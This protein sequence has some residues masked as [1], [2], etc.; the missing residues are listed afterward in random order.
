MPF[1]AAA[2]KKKLAEKKAVADSVPASVIRPT[3]AAPITT[4]DTP[5]SGGFSYSVFK[6]KLAEKK[7]GRSASKTPEIFTPEY[8]RSIYNQ[9]APATRA[10]PP[11][12]PLDLG[13]QINTNTGG[14]TTQA[15]TLDRRAIAEQAARGETISTL[16]A[17]TKLPELSVTD[18]IKLTGDAATAEMDKKRKENMK[19]FFTKVQEIKDKPSQLVPFLAGA[20][21]AKEIY[22]LSQVLG[23][24]E[25]GTATKEDIEKAY[26][27]IE[28][29]EKES[30]FGYNVLNI[31]SMLP[32]FAGEIFTTKGLYTA[33]RKVATEAAEKVVK[34]YLVKGGKEMLEKKLA[35]NLMMKITTGL[36]GTAAITPLAGSTRITASTMEKMLPD[37]TVYK[38][39][40]GEL[41]AVILGEGDSLPT[42]FTKAFGEQ[43]VELASERAGSVLP[44]LKFYNKLDTATK[45]YLMRIAFIKSFQKLNPT[46][47]LADFRKV[48]K[49]AGW[50][51]VVGEMFEERV[52]DVGHGMLAEAGFGDQPLKLP[53][54]QQLAEELV[55]FS[56]IGGG[57]NLGERAIER[58]AQRG[59]AAGVERGVVPPAGPSG[60]S[61]PAGPAGPTGLTPAAADALAGLP[62]AAQVAQPNIPP[63]GRKTGIIT[64]EN[65]ETA[66]DYTTLISDTAK[67]SESMEEFKS[68]V[69]G[70]AYNKV[71]DDSYVEPINFDSE[72]AGMAL[73]H[74]LG[75]DFENKMVVPGGQQLLPEFADS[76]SGAIVIDE[77]GKV[78]QGFEDLL[79]TYY[80]N[81][82]QNKTSLPGIKVTPAG[83][84]GRPTNKQ[85]KL[86]EIYT[87]AQRQTRMFPGRTPEGQPIVFRGQPVATAAP[88]IA[89][90]VGKP[91]P[92]KPAAPQGTAIG[93]IAAEREREKTNADF[94]EGDTVAFRKIKNGKLTT[95][96]DSKPYRIKQLFA[97]GEIDN[98]EHILLEDDK[99]KELYTTPAGIEKVKPQYAMAPAPVKPVKKE[100]PKEV[101]EAPVKKAAPKKEKPSI[102]DAQRAKLMG[103]AVNPGVVERIGAALGEAIAEAEGEAPA[104]QKEKVKQAVAEQPKTIKQVAE[105]TGILA[106]NVRRILGMGAKDGT[107]TR[108]EKG[109]YVMTMKNGQDVAFIYPSD[110]IETL[111]KLAEE[112]FKADM[113]FLDIP[114]IT[115]GI[116]SAN[117]QLA[118]KGI[119]PDQFRTVVKAVK[120]IAKTDDTP[121]FHMFSQSKTGEKDMAVYNKVLLDEGLKPIAKGNY[122]KVSKEGKPLTQP[123]RTAPLP[124]EGILLLS[125]S[126]KINTDKAITLDFT[127]TRPRGYTTEKPEELL[128][129]LI[130]LGTREGDMVLDPFAGSGVTGAAAIKSGRRATLIE[131]GVWFDTK[132]EAKLDE[133][134]NPIKIVEEFTV[135][136]VQA[137]VEEAR[138]RE[139]RPAE[140]TDLQAAIESG[141]KVAYTVEG[142][143]KTYT[144]TAYKNGFRRFV[145]GEYDQ[146]YSEH[147]L[148]E[149]KESLAKYIK[150][151]APKREVPQRAV[152]TRVGVSLV[153]PGEAYAKEERGRPIEPT[154]AK[155]LRITID[156]DAIASYVDSKKTTK[157]RTANINDLIIRQKRGVTTKFLELP[158][159]KNRET[160]SYGFLYNLSKSDSFGI[161][162]NE[163]EII[164][165]VLNTKFK[166]QKSINMADFRREVLDN[167]LPLEMRRTSSHATAGMS[168]IGLD[169]LE[170]TTYIFN[171][172]FAHGETGHF[173][174]DYD[175]FI[176][177]KEEDLEIKKVPAQRGNPT[178]QYAV[179]RKGITLT[180]DNI[181][182]YVYT[183]ADTED[184][185]KQWISQRLETGKNILPRRGELA[186]FGTKGLFAHFRAADD[187]EKKKTYIPEWQGDPFQR[188]RVE[189]F[190]Q[191]GRISAIEERLS[192]YDDQ[193]ARA[194][195]FRIDYERE[196]FN[197]QNAIKFID[198]KEFKK[199]NPKQGEFKYVVLPAD[200]QIPGVVDSDVN[201]HFVDRI[202]A[203]VEDGKFNA[204]A[205]V[206]HMKSKME[207]AEGSI[208]NYKEDLEQYNKEKQELTDELKK[209][210]E[211]PMSKEEKLFRDYTDT[212]Y[213]RLVREAISTK[214]NEGFKELYFPTPRTVAMV[215]GYSGAPGIPDE[216]GDY[217]PYELINTN[218]NEDLSV[219]DEIEYLGDRHTVLEADNYNITVSKSSDV[220]HFSADDYMRDDIQGRWEET[221]SELKSVEKD[222]NIK[223]TTP[224]A[225]QE[226]L[227]MIPIVNQHAAYNSKAEDTERVKKELDDKMKEEN[228][229]LASRV[230]TLEKYTK[231]HKL[232]VKKV[233]VKEGITKERIHDLRFKDRLEEKY[234]IPHSFWNYIIDPYRDDEPTLNQ[235]NE[236]TRA[237]IYP[238]V[239]EAKTRLKEQ[240]D[241]ISDLQDEYID[242]LKKIADRE[243]PSEGASKGIPKELIK[244]RTNNYWL[245]SGTDRVLEWMADELEETKFKD[246]DAIAEAYEQ[247]YS[248]DMAENYDPDFE[249]MYG[250]DNVFFVE[251]GYD[252]EVWVTEGET[253]TLSQPDQYEEVVDKDPEEFDIEKFSDSNYTVL[254]FYEQQLL[255]YVNKLRRGN[256]ELVTDEN[257]VQWLKTK[258]TKEDKQPPTAY[259][260]K[261]NLAKI[262]LPITD[263]Q[264]VEILKLNKEIF[265]DT[266]IRI[267]GQILANDEALGSYRDRIIKILDR[268]GDPKSTFY[269]EAVHKYLDVFTTRQEYIDLLKEA[270]A[271]YQLK[272]L[273]AV[274]EKLA[275]DFIQYAK[276]REGVYGKLRLLFDKIL[277]RIGQYIGNEKKIAKLYNDIASGKAARQATVNVPVTIAKPGEFP[278]DEGPTGR[279]VMAKVMSQG[280]QIYTDLQKR[281]K[282]AKNFNEFLSSLT[283]PERQIISRKMNDTDVDRSIARFYT[284]I[285]KGETA[286]LR[287]LT[288]DALTKATMRMLQVRAKLQ[289]SR[290][291]T[292]QDRNGGGIAAAE[293]DRQWDMATDFQKIAPPEQW[294]IYKELTNY[295]KLVLESSAK[296][297]GYF[298]HPKEGLPGY[299]GLE[300][301]LFKSADGYKHLASV[302]AHEL[303]HMFDYHPE[304]TMAKG[305][306]LGRLYN[307]VYSF[308]N[309]FLEDPQVA[310]RINKIRNELMPAIMRDINQ[311]KDLVKNREKMQRLEH[312]LDGLERGDIIK[313]SDV[314][315]E[316]VELSKIRRPAL[317]ESQAAKS[318]RYRNSAKELYADY[319]ST[320]FNNPNQAFEIAPI[321]TSRFF[322]KLQNKPD[323]YKQML[324]IQHILSNGSLATMENRVKNLMRMF[325]RSEDAYKGAL[326]ERMVNKTSLWDS[327]QD[328]FY[329]KYQAVIDK[330]MEK[331]EEM[332]KDPYLDPR[333]FM[334]RYDYVSDIMHEAIT[335]N[336]QQFY[337]EMLELGIEPAEM[338]ALLFAQRIA[339]DPKR[340]DVANPGAYTPAT[341]KEVEDYFKS[342]T[343]NKEKAKKMFEL[344][345]KF[346]QG[347]LNVIKTYPDL[348]PPEL[349]AEIKAMEM[350]GMENFYAPFN[351]AQGIRDYLPPGMYHQTGNLN[352]TNNILHNI[353]LKMIGVV[354]AGEKNVAHGKLIMTL[355]KYFPED[356]TKAKT[357]P[358][359]RVIG[360]DVNGNPVIIYVH[361]PLPPMDRSKGTISAR[362]G[363]Q[364][365]SFYIPIAI[366]QSL[367]NAPPHA[368]ALFANV[369]NNLQS[370]SKKSFTV[371]SPAFQMINFVIRDPGTT[372]DTFR[373]VERATWNPLRHLKAIGKMVQYYGKATGHATGFVRGNYSGVVRGMLKKGRLISD[374][375]TEEKLKTLLDS[376]DF[377][378]IDA[379]LRKK[380]IS[381]F[382]RDIEEGLMKRIAG[383]VAYPVIKLYHAM[384]G[385]GQALEAIPKI[386]AEMYLT[387]K[388]FFPTEEEQT[389]WITNRVGSPNFRKKGRATGEIS[390]IMMF[391]NATLRGLETMA[392]L[393]IDPR[394]RAAVAWGTFYFVFLPTLVT[395]MAELGLF[396]GDDEER[397]KLKSLADQVPEQRKVNNFVIPIGKYEGKAMAIKIPMSEKDRF[398]HAIIRYAL[399]SIMD[400]EERNLKDMAV[401]IGQSLNY[402]VEQ[403]P[404]VAPLWTVMFAAYNTLKGVNPVDP[405]T[406]QNVFRGMGDTSQMNLG[407]L[408]K[409]EIFAKWAGQKLGLSTYTA[410]IPGMG[411]ILYE[412]KA[413]SKM[414]WQR[415]IAENLIGRRFFEIT[416]AG[417]TE[418]TREVQRPAK[419]VIAEK[420]EFKDQ[421][422]KKAV[423]EFKTN[424]P[425]NTGAFVQDNII[426]K[427][428]TR[429]TDEERLN[430]IDAFTLGVVKQ[431][432]ITKLKQLTGTTN[433]KL[434]AVL[435]D[436]WERN[437]PADEYKPLF[438]MAVANGIITEATVNELI[439][440]KAERLNQ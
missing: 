182:N 205:F 174:G 260:L 177:V 229:V 198:S 296:Y 421:V 337:Q 286:N 275:E 159:V 196:L 316:L 209:V 9:P 149:A 265:G 349:M 323:V 353:L 384:T 334:G 62:A 428:D 368:L 249:G 150:N 309:S 75:E 147:T 388:A 429:F 382:E 15:D 172:P 331:K 43:F 6:Q 322:D 336:F 55:A 324:E 166:D 226:V 99:G 418:H 101:P 282:N 241:K 84:V 299:I 430:A 243:K 400:E 318:V 239:M 47:K 143:G 225:A 148:E 76:G 311:G 66:P 236:K 118:Y 190:G 395:T 140:K 104:T 54:A 202:N 425:K 224:A 126:G 433:P 221:L 93:E 120:D 319:M 293:F 406:K 116:R 371:L 102:T 245:D 7:A 22:D 258:L 41:K 111:P 175:D 424:P 49:A 30:T 20:T 348:F 408:R 74:T 103:N 279:Q 8:A 381:V 327:I 130:K 412:N 138:K 212:W 105:E 68:R 179:V 291:D 57:V 342:Q 121:I 173:S 255:K 163:K 218:E 11:A 135:P 27:V 404:S 98:K 252:T 208:K 289:A 417:E 301:D 340:Q 115:A 254:K 278:I 356:I 117:R 142:N 256:L 238:K 21:E 347:L 127:L 277:L 107:F 375:H 403:L 345:K 284:N 158:D 165:N 45:E 264:E 65:L 195:S 137:A 346:R 380:G 95:E 386:A 372:L 71:S 25:D 145:D 257:K 108:V 59:Q 38:D 422:I 82:G 178:D 183:V 201:R 367:E 96:L 392:K 435:L 18:Q 216:E 321:F 413:S 343:D 303:G 39:E 360:R 176:G 228:Q 378:A 40:Q 110:A 72:T 151:T 189:R 231:L 297:Y 192:A 396:G 390:A 60:P 78:L 357:S 152:P 266:D 426:S 4:A 56:L 28:D 420:D 434:K 36:V 325:K 42:A 268:Q 220:H 439:N 397:K 170:A 270:Q 391:Y 106:P 141:E 162:Q 402:A 53:S 411:D 132:G 370:F 335:T 419:Q 88:V 302:F 37:F 211:A 199:M 131:N 251:N 365:K 405:Y 415:A 232:L 246:I 32:S 26:K 155:T 12:E 398:A 133:A 35:E 272:D 2:F 70:S 326:K 369:I 122:T 308:R 77:N 79:D 354:Y 46:A 169:N 197:M 33:S 376:E 358:E 13:L 364:L 329:Y 19:T 235:V 124:P 298:A 5:V 280:E 125:K 253:E 180:P 14:T 213:Q 48:L 230:D 100:E 410:I 267:T 144:L 153:R 359:G 259:R 287:G 167:V 248:E 119:T 85:L 168:R 295:A 393:W 61:G 171:S 23:R 44:E 185:A 383:K 261:D 262:G 191:Q 300:R 263:K 269:H 407:K 1:D 69:L 338:S 67:E 134:G 29:S 207:S 86:N 350:L 80:E 164:Q 362:I 94:K 366:A 274:E 290:Y 373:M 306:V 341:A 437:L 285:T 203:Y 333:N 244:D 250:R 242:R 339:H 438:D 17:G 399:L 317:W 184:Q 109:V 161:K 436:D 194:I 114:Y 3:T 307:L 292:A 89:K 81:L 16:P 355:Q 128:T 379:T 401:N 363:G 352:D 351:I 427:L 283:E 294:I 320:L 332:N 92:V 223:L 52:A 304:F 423:E 247:K 387:D 414:T 123:M 344:A 90:P 227:N 64:T 312:E 187:M 83:K 146:T 58:A 97:V 219:G 276:S 215:E 330:A 217:M 361:K 113:V 377:S 271:Q 440:I 50:N 394:S 210:K 181:E 24:V 328:A 154:K 157:F 34:K 281:A 214:A 222:F 91:K 305:D 237:I 310:D 63:T 409:A 389:F 160:G 273:A 385:V 186:T 10:T 374:Y 431:S 233:V 136:R 188:S 204:D 129:A 73:S 193:I 240:Q 313:N 416:S 432:N 234:G 112:G 139:R 87:G 315:A 156:D 51:G 288:G 206:V 314:R 200:Y 31:I